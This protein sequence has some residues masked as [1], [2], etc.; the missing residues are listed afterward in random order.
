MAGGNDV[1]KKAVTENVRE[2]T[3]PLAAGLGL[4]LVDVEL[5][6]ERSQT[7]LRVLIDREAGVRLE[8]CEQLNRLLGDELD[9]V[10]PIPYSY[11]LEV[12]SAGLERPLKKESDFTRFAGKRVKIKLFSPLNDKKNFN[13]IL[14]GFEEGQI[15][16]QDESTGIVRIPFSQV[17]KA[18]LVYEFKSV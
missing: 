3:V 16:L 10:D 14:S 18:N 9:R 4:E 15:L 6:T 1:S 13:G 12:S 7:V 2:M 8:D 17:V 11:S 5:V